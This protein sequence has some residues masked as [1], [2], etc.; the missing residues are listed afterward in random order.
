LSTSLFIKHIKENNL[1]VNIDDRS[2]LSVVLP[3]VVRLNSTPSF[4]KILKQKVQ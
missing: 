1:W 3:V 2:A 4:G